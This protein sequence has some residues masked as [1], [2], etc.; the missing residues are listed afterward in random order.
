[1][2]LRDQLAKDTQRN[3][4]LRRLMLM[5]RTEA[6]IVHV[7]CIG[8]GDAFISRYWPTLRRE[9]S[10]RKRLQLTVAD[11][12]ELEKLA[13][14]RVEKAEQSDDKRAATDLRALYNQLIE[15]VKD[16]SPVKYV[17][18]N[19]PE[20]ESWYNHLRADI[21]FILVPDAMHISK[22]ETWLKRSSL[23]FIEKP[24]NR[25]VREAQEFEKDLRTMV[26]H[27]G[28]DLPV[29]WVCP[30]DHYLAKIFHY[31]AKKARDQLFE[32]IGALSRVEFEILESGPIESWRAPSLEAG[33]I[34]D[35]FSHVLAMISAELNLSSF[36]FNRIREIKVAQHQDCPSPVTSETFAYFDFDL[37]DYE[38]KRIRVTGSVG[39]GVGSSDEKFL[40]FVGER[41]LIKCD[42]GPSSLNGIQI[43]E[44]KSGKEK[45][46]YEVGHGHSEFLKTLLEGRYLEEPVGGLTGEI[47]I[48]I[49]RILAAIRDRVPSKI[50]KHKIGMEKRDILCQ[51]N[52]LRL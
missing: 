36:R 31:D 19:N 8:A 6:Q 27:M 43:A 16:G 34:Y 30:F 15:D 39:K 12:D 28:G 21:V 29:T 38:G 37:L 44:G 50:S 33:M 18:L 35:L 25:D 10:G 42:L 11:V 24:Y 22:A 48:E 45:P 23:I 52:T 40:N 41:G 14:N 1:M 49:L 13:A 51:A 4:D 9:A 3:A 32:R 7:V 26:D 47:A 17:N 5:C 20:D 46:L 2:T